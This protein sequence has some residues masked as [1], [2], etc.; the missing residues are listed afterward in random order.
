MSYLG[1]VNFSIM[2]HIFG[3]YVPKEAFDMCVEESKKQKYPV[4]V[5]SDKS[6]VV[7]NGNKTY[8]V[9]E[10]AFRLQGGFV[11]EEI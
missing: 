8:L 1:G 10:K 5:L 4:Y 2:P 6:A 3:E 7:V 11:Q 9:G